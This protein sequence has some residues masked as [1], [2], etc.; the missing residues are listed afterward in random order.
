MKK[1]FSKAIAIEVI[2]RYN[3][4][5]KR[6]KELDPNCEYECYD[7]PDGDDV[8]IAHNRVLKR[9]MDD[10]SDLI[11]SIDLIEWNI[12]KLEKGKANESSERSE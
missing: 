5:V 2:R 7:L 9:F 8:S 11:S 6:F 3:A 10:L 12:E 4:S 1:N